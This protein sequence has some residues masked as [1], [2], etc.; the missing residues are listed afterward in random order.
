MKKRDIFAVLA[1]LGITY[2][3]FFYDLGKNDR[4]IIYTN[5]SKFLDIHH[6]A[7]INSNIDRD[8]YLD[9]LT[10][11]LQ[12]VENI[13]IVDSELSE[14]SVIRGVRG[15]MYKSLIEFSQLNDI[16][17]S[18]VEYSKDILTN[19]IDYFIV[20]NNL[21]FSSKEIEDKELICFQVDIFQGDSLVFTNQYC[22]KNPNSI[23]LPKLPGTNV[24]FGYIIV[25]ENNERVYN[26]FHLRR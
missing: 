12:Q 3:I 1:V 5:F 20:G 7:V 22:P 24:R 6:S 21:I 13:L 16:L 2:L 26:Y 9:T 10:Y 17:E 18:R 25:N 14:D 15:I 11:Y 4:S 8:R 19:E 23:M